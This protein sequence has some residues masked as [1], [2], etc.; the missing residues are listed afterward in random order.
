MRRWSPLAFARRALLLLVV[1]ALLTCLTVPARAATPYV[2]GISDQ[3]LPSW[4]TGFPAS[5]F[6]RFFASDWVSGGHIKLAR[7]VV[8]WNAMS[9]PYSG[10]RAILENWLRDVHSI[11]LV[12]DVGLTSYDGVYPSSSAQYRKSLEELL[13]RAQAM[14]VAVQ[15]V[16][17]WNEPN[18][19]GHESPAAAAGFTN[20]ASA[21]CAGGG[22]CAVV[23]GDLE[24]APGAGA[25]ERAYER[26]LS[27]V[28]AIWGVHAYRSVEAMSEAPYLNLVENMPGGGAGEQVWITEVAARRCH[29][30]NGDLVEN[31]EIGQ[32]ERARWLVDTLIPNRRPEHVFYYEFLLKERRRPGCPSEPEDEALYVPSGDPNAPDAPRPAASFVFGGAGVPAAYTGA[33]APGTTGATATLTGSVYPGGL[34][35]ASYR[36]QYGTTRSYGRDSSSQEAG[37]STGSVAASV[38]VV[39]GLAASTTY[40]YRLVAWNREG[41]AGQSYGADRTF[42]TPSLQDLWAAYLSA[43]W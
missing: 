14:G 10:D 35:D 36:F 15:Y 16:E 26:L 18:N 28:P 6:A 40:H 3:S 29:D 1:S 33:A 41:A 21:V 17:S 34:L 2:D 31:G 7:Y 42:A 4:D 19:Q 5:S 8:Q 9:P 20:A 11:G 12:P 22:G 25:F 24:D 13:A 27:P 43:G 39:G 32:A 38:A 23:A 37:S 30:Y